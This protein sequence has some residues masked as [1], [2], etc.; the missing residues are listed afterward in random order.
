MK[1][2]Q[3]NIANHGSGWRAPPIDVF[4]LNAD[5]IAGGMWSW[6]CSIANSDLCSELSIARRRGSC[7][8]DPDT[9]THFGSS[10]HARG[11]SRMLPRAPPFKS[12]RRSKA[13][14]IILSPV[15]PWSP[16]SRCQHWLVPEQRRAPRPRMR[17]RP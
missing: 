8:C 1:Q 4:N 13:T 3:T 9:T 12:Q 10:K 7:Y 17:I 15:S 14:R 6:P 11:G 16:L 5:K 2:E